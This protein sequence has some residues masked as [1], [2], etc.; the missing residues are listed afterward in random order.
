[1]RLH[2]KTLTS[3][4]PPSLPQLNECWGIEKEEEEEV[5]DSLLDSLFLLEA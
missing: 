1:M 5:E 2:G 4:S 3:C